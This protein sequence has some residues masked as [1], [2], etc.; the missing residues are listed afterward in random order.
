MTT[1]S[2]LIEEIVS[3][4]TGFSVN[5]DQQSVL[6]AAIGTGDLTLAVEDASQFG[7][8]VIEVGTEMMEVKSVDASS[9]QLQLYAFGRGARGSAIAT[10]PVGTRVVM[11]PTWPRYIIGREVNNVITSLYPTLFA[12]KELAPFL[13][14]TLLTQFNMPADA[15]HVLDVRYFDETFQDWLRA[16]RWEADHSMP[17]TS[18]NGAT[19]F[20]GGKVLN[21]W[22]NILPGRTV[23]VL[24]AAKPTKLSALT[25]DYSI[26]GFEPGTKDLIVLGVMAKMMQF[27]ESA[28]VQVHSVASN[29]AQPNNPV[30]AATNLARDM[31]QQFQQRLLEEQ[32]VQSIKYPPRVHRTR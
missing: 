8:G 20:A 22:D 12:V 14:D 28:R 11:S 7:R 25:D 5:M 1:Y 9:N 6:T 32:R 23:R 16:T 24:Y 21:I 4:L 13:M 17:T 27:A 10:H 2:D 18:V 19:G 15:E 3:N 30:G 26:T 31:R 29:T